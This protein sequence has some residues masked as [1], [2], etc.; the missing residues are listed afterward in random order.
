MSSNIKNR[1]TTNYWIII[2]RLMNRNDPTTRRYRIILYCI[3]VLSLLLVGYK[4]YSWEY[5]YASKMLKLYN[6]LY[7]RSYTMDELRDQFLDCVNDPECYGIFFVDI[8]SHANIYR[9]YF[10]DK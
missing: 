6:G 2:Q 3:I 5:R 8:Y 7:G 1:N 4:N 9:T 10:T